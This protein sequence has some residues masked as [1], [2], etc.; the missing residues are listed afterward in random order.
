M[1][2]LRASSIIPLP[3]ESLKLL[4][5]WNYLIENRISLHYDSLQ[6]SY[7]FFNIVSFVNRRI[8]I[9]LRLLLIA[10]SL[11]HNNF[12]LSFG[13]IRCV[14]SFLLLLDHLKIHINQ[15]ILW[16]ICSLTFCW[17]WILNFGILIASLFIV[18]ANLKVTPRTLLK[19]RFKCK[20]MNSF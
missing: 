6:D 18:S 2:S 11:I 13:A 10:C 7:L 19:R 9:L 17:R 14:I 15:S 12:F 16:F 1:I 4:N 20:G 5:L 3:D 8:F